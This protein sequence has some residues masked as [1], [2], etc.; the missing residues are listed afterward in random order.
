MD[1]GAWLAAVHVV[2]TRPWLLGCENTH[3]QLELVIETYV[4]PG[5]K[6]SDL[7][8]LFPQFTMEKND[9]CFEKGPSYQSAL[10]KFVS[11]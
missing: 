1:R 9:L 5:F 7:R 11:S 6:V 2:E 3:H 4:S 8:M 10:M